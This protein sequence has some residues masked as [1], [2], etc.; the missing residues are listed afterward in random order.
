VIK[1]ISDIEPE[2]R[3]LLCCARPHI[4][5]EARAKIAGLLEA[6]RSL[7][8]HPGPSRDWCGASTSC[9]RTARRVCD[10]L[11]QALR[12]RRPMADTPV[13]SILT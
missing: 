2:Y 7:V 1:A 11:W 4:G 13:C 10:G 3:L 8:R 12:L 6:A 5:E 9:V